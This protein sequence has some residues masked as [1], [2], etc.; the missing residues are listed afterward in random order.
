MNVGDGPVYLR[1]VAIRSKIPANRGVITSSGFEIMDKVVPPH[2]F[3]SYFAADR[4]DVTEDEA[5]RSQFDKKRLFHMSR[6]KNGS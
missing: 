5:R 1:N 3:Y 2:E 4:P 6:K